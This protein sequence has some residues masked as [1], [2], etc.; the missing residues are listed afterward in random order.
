MSIYCVI[1]F[2]TVF[3]VVKI[4]WFLFLQPIA[5][6]KNTRRICDLQYSEI[7]IYIPL[8]SVV[9]NLV[10]DF[11]CVLGSVCLFWS[12]RYLHNVG[13]PTTSNTR[14]IETDITRIHKTGFIQ[15]SLCKIKGLF[16][17]YMGLDERKPIFVGLRT[18]KAQSICP[19][20]SAPLL[21][22][23]RKVSYLN[24]PQVKCQASPCW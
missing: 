15:T 10:L 11:C 13:N 19:A 9:W 8:F 3:R 21:F 5:P 23:F 1:E 2:E 20:W 14:N 6:N 4:W 18:T 7:Q 24:L 12:N 17:N 16:M 22:P